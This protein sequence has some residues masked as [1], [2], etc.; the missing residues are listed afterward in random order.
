VCSY[1]FGTALLLE[2]R[3][4][5]PC[6]LLG[7]LLGL[8]PRFFG[9]LLGLPS[10]VFIGLLGLAARSLRAPSVL[11]DETGRLRLEREATRL[12]D[13]PS[14]LGFAL[15]GLLVLDQDRLLRLERLRP[16]TP[17]VVVL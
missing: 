10:R 6:G 14:G 13:P 7:R 9:R 17:R 15:G 4:L 16:Q 3:R 8:V 2:A 5:A 1:L 11:L 12:L